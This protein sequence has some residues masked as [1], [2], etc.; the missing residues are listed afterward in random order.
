MLR[1]TT[2]KTAISTG[3][4]ISGAQCEAFVRDYACLPTS[5]AVLDN[6]FAR[7]E[8][9]GPRPTG[10]VVKIKPDTFSIVNKTNATVAGVLETAAENEIGHDPY[11]LSA[12][13]LQSIRSHCLLMLV[14]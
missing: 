4:L 10:T 11:V 6:V 9:P 12:G 2:A 3:A 8:G 1:N 5:N 7:T 14:C 13:C